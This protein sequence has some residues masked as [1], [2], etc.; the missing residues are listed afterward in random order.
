[1][2]LEAISPHQALAVIAAEDQRFPE[3]SGFDF[4]AIERAWQDYRQ[5]K[6][7]RGASTISQ[8]VVKNLYLWPGRSLLRK[9]LEVWFTLLVELSWS[10]RRIL[11]VYLNIAQFGRDVYGAEA[12][13]RYFFQ[14]P[15]SALSREQAALLAAVLPGPV[16]YR[17]EAPSDY[18][19]RKRS[20]I[21]QQMR[22]LGGLKFLDK[23]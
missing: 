4:P 21:L 13:S 1:V 6:S 9:G 7:L 10:K 11:E 20:W 2:P 22:Q 14:R 12:A 16:Q 23:L 8:Q 3:H 5:G 15:A 17:V 18:V 19:R